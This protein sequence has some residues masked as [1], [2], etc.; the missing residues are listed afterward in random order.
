M[1]TVSIGDS[2]HKMSNLFSGKKYET[3]SVCHLLKFLPSMLSINKMSKCLSGSC[4]NGSSIWTES[5]EK[6]VWAFAKCSD[7]DYQ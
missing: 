1:Q 4:E 5:R 7:S 3:I 6:G 2:L